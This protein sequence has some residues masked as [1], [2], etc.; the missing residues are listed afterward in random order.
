MGGAKRK[1]VGEKEEHRASPRCGFWSSLHASEAKGAR[2]WERRAG[3][4]GGEKREAASG[5]A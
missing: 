5:L 2:R 3:K 4:K 1:R